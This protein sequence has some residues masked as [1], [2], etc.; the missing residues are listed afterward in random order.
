MCWNQF[1]PTLIYDI[2]SS[3]FQDHRPHIHQQLLEF[4]Q[5]DCNILIIIGLSILCTP[6]CL[7]RGL[8]HTWPM[9]HASPTNIIMIKAMKLSSWVHKQLTAAVTWQDIGM[10]RSLFA[11]DGLF[12]SA[13]IYYFGFVLLGWWFR[14]RSGYKKKTQRRRKSDTGKESRGGCL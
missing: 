6:N 14:W 2:M 9:T 3:T 10:L 8:K 4:F 12:Y 5:K 13:A 7:L 1:Q 11:D